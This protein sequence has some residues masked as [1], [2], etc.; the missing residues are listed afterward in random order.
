MR[1]QLTRVHNSGPICR[2][3]L[4][5][6]HLSDG[7]RR[8]GHLSPP[9]PPQELIFNCSAKSA[10][11]AKD[12]APRYGHTKWESS[13]FERAGTLSAVCWPP[14]PISRPVHLPPAVVAFFSTYL[15]DCSAVDPLNKQ[16]SI[17]N[18]PIPGWPAPSGAFSAGQ[19]VRQR[20]DDGCC[21]NNN[22]HHH[23]SY[24]Y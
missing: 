19:P 2:I 16:I 13:F 6:E 15:S 14:K 9:S 21:Y 7:L 11:R 23:I 24:R 20:F 17:W 8:A 4:A 1:P 5:S 3:G 12:G 22:N 10:R 18:W